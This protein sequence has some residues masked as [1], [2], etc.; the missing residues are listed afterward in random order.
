MDMQDDLKIA[1]LLCTRLCHDLTGPIGAVNNGAEFLAE[2]GFN[3][4][5]QAVD[6]I[7]TSA[8]SAVARLQFYRIAY[9]RVKESGEASLAEHQ[10][11]AQ[12][13]F[14]GSRVTLDWPEAHT[15]A[16]GVS[17]SLRMMR[18][19]YNLL[20]ILSASLLKGG[21][22]HVR[23]TQDAKGKHVDISAEGEAIKWE[24][25]VQALLEG[26]R[27]EPLTPKNVQLCVTRRLCEE[28]GVAF[29]FTVAEQKIAVSATRPSTAEAA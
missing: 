13:F 18:L 12:A 5:H 4:Q 17:L 15:D 11:I 19:L 23:I 7:A 28:L 21:T 6:L 14:E 26:K 9:G 22:V 1:E 10:A 2:E 20:V 3:M 27:E 25:D 16:A 24:S 8:A 29:H